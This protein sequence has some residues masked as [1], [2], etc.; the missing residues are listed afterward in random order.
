MAHLRIMVTDAAELE[1]TDKH[2]VKLKTRVSLML[3]SFLHLAHLPRIR[4]TVHTVN[5]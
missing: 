5:T 4:R 1:G 3:S 2:N